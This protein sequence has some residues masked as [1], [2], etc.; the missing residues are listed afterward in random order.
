[1]DF[2]AITT[3]NEVETIGPLVR[4]LR[5]Q[6]LVVIVVDDGSSDGT[7]DA[8]REAGAVVLEQVGRMGIGPCLVRAWHYALGHGAER[9]VQLDAGGSHDPDQALRLLS[10]VG[11]GVDVVLGTRFRPG[12][13]YVGGPWW[14]PLLSAVAA[15]ACRWA[16]AGAWYSDWTSGYR[17][18]SRRALEELVGRHYF[19]RMHGWQIEVLAMAGEAGL[20][21]A[22]LPITYKAGRSSFNGRVANEAINVWMQI[23]HH[24]GPVVAPAE[25]VIG[26]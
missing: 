3:L 25:R 14:R 16:Q 1:M 24:R 10:R 2:A 5:T 15:W 18:F 26:D 7:A 11:L 8:A 23:L 22:E 17:A 20:V 4:A 12:S 21:V 6:G 19:A 9:L 13:E